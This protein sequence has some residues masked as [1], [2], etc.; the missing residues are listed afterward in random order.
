MAKSNTKKESAEFD[1]EKIRRFTQ[2]EFSNLANTSSELPFCYQIGSDILIGK[3]KILKIND[4][5]WR[6]IE[7][8]QQVF[9]FFNRKD[10]I[11]YCIAVHKNQMKLAKDIKECDSL[12]NRL[13]FDAM[14]YRH[15]YKTAIKN[16]DPWAEEYFSNRYEETMRRIEHTKKEIK[17]NLNLAK[18]I[19][20]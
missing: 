4:E 12:L 17:K 5:C 13:E 18:Y 9:D 14:L 20:V 6:V 8:G 11:F 10:A 2:N 1:V 3:N 15:R 19:K 16:N 7:E